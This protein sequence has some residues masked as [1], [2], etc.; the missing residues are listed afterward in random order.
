MGRRAWALLDE[1]WRSLDDSCSHLS[2]LS[3]RISRRHAVCLTI[4]EKF[5][6]GK[7][8]TVGGRLLTLA[9][10]LILATFS[11]ID[12]FRSLVHILLP[13]GSYPIGSVL[14]LWSVSDPGINL[15]PG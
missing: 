8:K 14:G 15:T 3:P 6:S 2:E 4:P 7:G 5:L 13:E 9:P 11:G 1:G 12:F 10:G